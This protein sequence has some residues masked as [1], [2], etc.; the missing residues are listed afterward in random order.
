MKSIFTSLV[1]ISLLSLALLSCSKDGPYE[2]RQQAQAAPQVINASVRVG[3]AYVLNMGDGSTASIV[4]QALHYQLSEITTAPNGGAV[5]K[6]ISGKGFSGTD[7]VTLQ[8]TLTSTMQGSGC[9]NNHMNGSSMA[10]AVK[11]IVIRLN[12]AN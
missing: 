8:Q 4:T 12:V 3:Q 6:Y 5:Y 1:G 11:T 10:T 7:E 9:H 2:M